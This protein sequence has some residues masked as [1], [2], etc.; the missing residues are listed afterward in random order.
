MVLS[1]MKRTD[2]VEFNSLMS[3]FDK[4]QGKKEQA[5]LPC[6][7]FRGVFK[8][9]SDPQLDVVNSRE[10]VNLFLAGQGSGKTHV[11]GVLSGVFIW[12]FPQVI[13][14]IAAN[15]YGQLNHSTI[16]RIKEVWRD[17]YGWEEYNEYTN[18]GHYV[19]GVQPPAHFES[20]HN[21]FERYGNIA[22]FANGATIYIG[23][24]DNYKALDG[25][26]I[27]W[28]ILDETKD[29]KE[30]AVKD[31]ILGRLRMHGIYYTAKGVLTNEPRTTGKKP[32]ANK[33]FT[34]LYM[35]TSPAKVPW[36]NR[37]FKLDEHEMEIYR[38]IFSKTDYFAKKVDSNKFV[39]ISSTYLNAK[40]LPANYIPNQLASLPAGKQDMLIFGCPFSKAGGEFHKGFDRQRNTGETTYNP[41][42]PLHITFDFNVKP[43]PT[44]NVWQF[45][46]A[47][48]GVVEL[49]QIDEI[50]PESPR[51]KTT[52]ACRD[53]KKKYRSHRAGLFVY[54]DPAGKHE[55]T[56][57]ERGYNDFVLITNE[58][59]ELQPV[60]RV[61]SKA[62]PV[63][64]RG[65]FLDALF[66]GRV[67]GYR[68][69][70]GAHCTRTI[71]DYSNLK[72]A[73]DGTKLKE[74]TEDPDTKVRYQ[75]YGHCS[76][77]NDYFICEAL[78]SEF[79]FYLRG[80]AAKTPPRSGKKSKSSDR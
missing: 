46:P 66:E 71:A 39:T 15:T 63:V 58:L 53:F 60:R 54:G 73:P 40:N 68:L 23:S 17:E 3:F 67:E 25:M 74:L 8:K 48:D 32:R 43:H 38:K 79:L 22:T 80:G 1:K 29:T 37:M 69:T 34:P 26:E 62:P 75:K 78:K 55:D 31:V 9:L 49:K 4:V 45:F 6:P 76:D 72:E 13:G 24:L 5:L 56:R 21:S 2:R 65:E 70:I 51:N 35:L 57:T 7:D 30:D 59:K 50:C 20:K 47:D 28:A 10:D 61:A 77:A 41:L 64:K 11:G 52:Y 36:I 27:G 19:I 14:L 44:L 16:K 18:K 12:Y 33:P 42:L